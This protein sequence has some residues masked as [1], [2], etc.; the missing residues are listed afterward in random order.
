M[1]RT[2]NSSSDLYERRGNINCKKHDL[3]NK[4]IDTDCRQL[5]S[6]LSDLI[7]LLVALIFC[8]IRCNIKCRDYVSLN[9]PNKINS[10][11]KGEVYT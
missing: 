5:D 2:L 4:Q 6:N 3:V 7:Y 8:D 9:T 1:I 11:F 10:L